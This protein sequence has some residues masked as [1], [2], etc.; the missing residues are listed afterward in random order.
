MKFDSKYLIGMLIILL[1]ILIS[2]TMF[3]FFISMILF[4]IGSIF[5]LLSKRSVIV[6][7]ISIILP[8]LITFPISV[9]VIMMFE[10]LGI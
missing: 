6:K 9:G 5:V 4:P 3:F 7:V 10:N 8:L 2:W 1:A